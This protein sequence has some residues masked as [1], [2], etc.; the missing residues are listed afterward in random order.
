MTANIALAA[1]NINK[2]DAKELATL[3]GI[4]EAKATAIIKYRKD[5]GNFQSPKDLVKVK[6]IGPKIFEKLSK[7]ITIK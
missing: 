1:I 6:G 7:E 2:A 3:P 4:G 5:N